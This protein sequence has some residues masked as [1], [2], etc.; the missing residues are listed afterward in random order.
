MLSVKSLKFVCDLPKLSQ[1][2]PILKATK[3]NTLNKLHRSGQGKRLG[4]GVDG[5][6][7]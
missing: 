1:I 3:I 7:G 4:G 5:G 2:I 6:R